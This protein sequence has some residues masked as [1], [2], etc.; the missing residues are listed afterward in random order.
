MRPLL[1]L[2]L[3]LLALPAL[4]QPLA[5]PPAAERLVPG[6]RA[7]WVSD[8]K[9]GC[10]LWAGGLEAGSSDITGSWSG[11]CPNG[12]AEG[13][14]RSV[15][16]WQVAGRM[17]E[18]IWE[19]PLQNGKAEGQGT[20]IVTEDGEVVSRERGRYH[21]DRLVQGR[22]ELPRAGLVYEGGWDLGHPH[23]EGELRLNNEVIRGQWE[24]G[25]LRRK[26]AWISFTRSPDQCEGQAT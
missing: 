13:T 3:P 12:P 1:F 17:R 5:E 14:G 9:G 6:G 24:H 2:T 8:G 18:M 26:D 10:W 16:R 21:L 25:C 7:G 4:A 20:L 22:L 19:G 15:V 23:G 11:D